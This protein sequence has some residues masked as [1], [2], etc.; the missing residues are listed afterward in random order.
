[1]RYKFVDLLVAMVRTGMESNVYDLLN[2]TYLEQVYTDDD[3]KLRDE[4]YN[5]TDNYSPNYF[6][7]PDYIVCS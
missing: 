7:K 3:K 2:N 6:L 5:Y 1:M 4:I